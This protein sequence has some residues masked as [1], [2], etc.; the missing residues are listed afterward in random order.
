MAPDEIEWLKGG[1]EDDAGQRAEER[2]RIELEL[3]R[4]A[5]RVVTIGPRLQGRFLRDLDAE[6][7]PSPVRL[8]PGFDR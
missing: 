1:R 3:A 6:G 2:T 5:A 4:N 8:D 7:L